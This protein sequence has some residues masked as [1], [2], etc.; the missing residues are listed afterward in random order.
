MRPKVVIFGEA[1]VDGRITTAPGVLLMFPE[2]RW[3]A[4]APKSETYEHLK[5]AYR[6]QSYLEGSLSLT[7]EG[8]PAEPLPPVEGDPAPLYQ[9]YLPAQIVNRPGAVGWFTCVDS[10]GRVRWFYKEFPD[11]AWKGWYLL[12]LVSRGTPPEYLAY[13]RR[14]E[15][16]YL[17]AGEG[18]VDLAGALEKLH[19]QLSVE[20]VLSTSPG[21]LG[22]A[23]LRA[24]LVDEIDI[25]FFPAVI[26]GCETSQ[27]VR[28]AR[29]AAR[30]DAR[31]AEAA[32]SQGDREW[33][34][35]VALRGIARGGLNAQ[36]DRGS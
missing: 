3:Q 30:A 5:Q 18:K 2:P 24:G 15:I 11:E 22:G 10:R 17:V 19:D 33:A 9:D 16:P 29:S 27:P 4:V 1:S 21:K 12:V 7:P 32:L 25:D 14:E 23:L 31:A 34:G 26:G 36:S 28:I 13:L 20:R 8:Q 35:V 6:P